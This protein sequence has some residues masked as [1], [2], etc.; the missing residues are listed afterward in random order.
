MT[1]LR[2]RLTRSDL[3]ALIVAAAFFM[4]GLDATIIAPAIPEMAKAFGADAA[5]LSSGISAYL[6]AV[7]VFIPVSGWAADRF[8]V[9]N[10]F[11][12]A[13]TVFTLA[14]VMCGFATSLSEFV[15][16]RV[17]QGVGGAMMS[18]VGRMEVLSKTPKERFMRAM[19][20]VSWPGLSSFIVGPPLGGF[21]TTYVSWQWIFFI[22]VPLGMIAFALV[23]RFFTNEKRPRRPFDW[24][25]FVLFG[26]ALGALIYGLEILGHHT[27]QWPIGGAMII[28]GATLG[29]LAVRHALHHPHPIISLGPLRV[30]TFS[31]GT[32]TGGGL[33]RIVIGSSSF[34]LPTMF[35]LAYGFDAFNAGLMMFALATGD[36]LMKFRASYFVRRF[37]LRP[38][39]IVNGLLVATGTLAL[40]GI[41]A[42][43]PFWG[44]F[45]L[46]FFVGMVRSQQFTCLTAMS[47]ADIP[48]D[49]MAN[50]TALSNMLMQ[51]SFALGVAFSA[52]VLVVVQ[53]VRG[54]G[55][56]I[57]LDFKVVLCV[58]ALMAFAS[59]YFFLRL[60]PSAG[61]NVSG[62]ASRN[63]KPAT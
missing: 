46:M 57:G 53:H 29:M 47:F 27:A 37:R 32:L 15:L 36:L 20:L 59:I 7:A 62:H 2:E 8:G 40:A 50:A 3:I 61:A 12:V 17:V 51:A 52:I 42:G 21:I 45:A 55:P 44:L 41:T 26:G 56:F 48:N 31:T 63:A 23:L 25:G 11:C 22:N 38:V 14:S 39:L 33:F 9:R 13:I 19:A 60:D 5:A 6:I 34:L 58:L 16:W 18:P 30:R 43:T 49:R 4:E 35:Q 10:V 28:A 1:R 24:R 54:G